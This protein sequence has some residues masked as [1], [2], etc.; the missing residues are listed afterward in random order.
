MNSLEEHAHLL[1]KN[2][3]EMWLEQPMID[4]ALI[5]TWDSLEMHLGG[6]S[7]FQIQQQVRRLYHLIEEYGDDSYVTLLRFYLWGLSTDS[8]LKKTLAKKIRKAWT[9]T[10]YMKEQVMRE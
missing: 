2:Y 7:Q 4:T 3:I 10:E 5:E 1:L 9:A 8:E 6:Q